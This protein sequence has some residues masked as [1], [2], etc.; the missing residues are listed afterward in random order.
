[1]AQRKIFAGARLRALRMSEKL[2]QR[3]LAEHLGISTSYLNQIE[4]NQ[5]P[6]TAALMLTLAGVF[7][8]DIS[9]F[10][11]ETADRLFVDLREVFADPLFQ[12]NAPSLI[13]LK[14]LTGNSHDTAHAI[15]R[16]YEAYRKANERLADMDAA[17]EEQPSGGFQTAYEE[18][19][20]FFHYA[21]NYFDPLDRAAETLAAELGAAPHLSEARLVA[22]L[23]ETHDVTVRF[24]EPD[25]PQTMRSFDRQSRVL[26]VNARLEPASRLFQLAAQLGAMEQTTL[27]GKITEAA[28]FKSPESADIC[29][30]GLTNYFAGALQMPYRAFL[31]AAEA[32]NY[33][34]DELSYRFG[35]SRE[36]VGHRLS[37]MQR[38][39]ARG[40]PFFFAR[41]DAAGTITKRHSATPLQFARFGGACP[42]W[43]VH[44]AFEERG[45]ILRQLAETPDGHRYLFLAW[46]EEKRLGG[47]RGPVRRYAY[48]LGCEIAQAKKLIYAADLDLS[49]AGGFDPIG[50]S[51]RIC[52]RPHCP[53]RSVPPLTAGIAVPEGRRA[54]VPFEIE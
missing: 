12:D 29:R 21:D 52:E 28:P 38:P 14:S 48:A 34:L 49:T 37:T 40:V 26:S 43:N 22:Y 45:H 15:L 35:A 46:S 4:N 13:E 33:D 42:L 18:V 17:M 11:T 47:Y 30:L 2:T 5:R 31:E 24:V 50:V 32:Q 53:Q 6:L 39:K 19:R 3:Q 27:I 7:D 20:D 44:R 25:D 36:Q 51:C 16:L 54:I 1:M 23:A 41:L 9:E 8:L 10:A